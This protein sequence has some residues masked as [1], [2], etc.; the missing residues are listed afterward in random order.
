MVCHCLGFAHHAQQVCEVRKSCA[1]TLSLARSAMTVTMLPDNEAMRQF[2]ACEQRLAF[3][4][5]A[6]FSSV[7]VTLSH[8]MHDRR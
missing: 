8:I 3:R 1:S 5:D 7:S 4:T 2:A 6:V